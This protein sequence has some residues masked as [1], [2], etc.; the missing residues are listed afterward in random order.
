MVLIWAASNG[1]AVTGLG[2]RDSSYITNFS[3]VV[4]AGLLLGWQASMA[5]TIASVLSGFGL[6]YAEQSGLI[7]NV[8]Y[9]PA[10]FAQD[11]TLYIWFE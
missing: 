1:L 9:P 2:I 6:V 3:I 4:M 10:A 5:V 11:I 7:G 8:S